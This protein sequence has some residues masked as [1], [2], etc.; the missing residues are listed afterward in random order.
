MKLSRKYHGVGVPSAKSMSRTKASKAD[1]MW[2]VANLYF[3]RV[4]DPKERV[5]SST[6]P[7]SAPAD[8]TIKV[9]K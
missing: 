4:Q 8:T 5:Q 1:H 6:Q 9:A 2:E 3:D 7:L